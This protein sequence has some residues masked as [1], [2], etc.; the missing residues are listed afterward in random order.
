MR[1]T[2]SQIAA[3]IAAGTFFLVGCDFEGSVIHV[4]PAALERPVTETDAARSDSDS[5]TDTNAEDIGSDTADSAT[6]SVS[7]M[8]TDA[9]TDSTSEPY[10]A[11]DTASD[12]DSA[13]LIDT[14]PQDSD[15]FLSNSDTESD[16]QPLPDTD[17][18]TDLG[19]FIT[20]DMWTF[21][22]IADMQ[23]G[24]TN[25]INHVRSMA[26][27]D[28]NAIALI[29]VGDLTHNALIQEWE[30]H[31]QA[32]ET[33]ALEAGLAADH[34]NATT[35]NWGPFTRFVGVQGNHDIY[36]GSWLQYWNQ[37]LP[38]QQTL[39]ANS[40]DGIY[41]TLDYGNTLFIILDSNHISAQQT[42]WLESVLHS[43]FALNARWKIALFHEP[44]YP[45]DS[46]SPKYMALPWVT[47]FETHGV[48]MVIH[49]HAHTFERTCPMKHGS[50]VPPG[51]PGVTYFIASGGGTSYL[52]T[53]NPQDIGTLSY[54]GRTDSYRCEEILADHDSLWNHF[55][56]YAV[57][58]CRFIVRCYDH[59]Y[60]E[61]GE[62]RHQFMLEKCTL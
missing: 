50:C 2:E 54:G 45:C 38:G 40:Q 36:S 25:G 26:M 59:D 3:W 43:Q 49:G 52:R 37:F 29:E 7:S 1:I 33:G 12:T 57:G 61:G 8:A 9:D 31:H 39:G 28:P 22:T 4:D 19:R 42:D 56:H 11:T 55:C 44:V 34:F 27:F 23:D 10:Q 53:V 18:E 47:L 14:E 35:D 6:D 41:F 58:N 5:A 32:L 24:P 17:T 48:D 30:A 62:L 13:P 46:K 51:E 16:T 20:D 60:W 21:F 15:T